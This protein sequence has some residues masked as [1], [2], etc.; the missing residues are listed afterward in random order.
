[1]NSV[2]ISQDGT[3]I[4]SGSDD[5]VIKIWSGDTKKEIL[6]LRGHWKSVRSVVISKNK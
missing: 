1:M 4:V 3:L 6:T 5:R 2:I